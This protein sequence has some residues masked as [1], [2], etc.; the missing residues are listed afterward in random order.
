MKLN[1]SSGKTLTEEES[2]NTP[3]SLGLAESVYTCTPKAGT[4]C[5]LAF[6]YR[7]YYSSLL[8]GGVIDT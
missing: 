6:N 1:Y 4:A 5:Y 3:F 7:N 2:R 8:L